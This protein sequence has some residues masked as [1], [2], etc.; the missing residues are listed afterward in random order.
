M[1]NRRVFESNGWT[2]EITG[3][4][5]QGGVGEEWERSG[6]FTAIALPCR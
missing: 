1:V 3:C 6:G 2:V 5:T 4:K